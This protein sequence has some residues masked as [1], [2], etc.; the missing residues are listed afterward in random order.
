[1][2][3]TKKKN[4]PTKTSLILRMAASLYLFYLAWGLKDAPASH[5]GMESLLY[6]AA[7]VAFVLVALIM[8]GLSLKAYIAGNY[9]GSQ[10]D[11]VE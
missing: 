10:S 3:N 9:S 11:D 7:I 8:G 4:H 6:M 1:M 5:T 2:D